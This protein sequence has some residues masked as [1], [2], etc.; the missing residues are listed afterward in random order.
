VIR[1]LSL[2]LFNDKFQNDINKWK[3]LEAETINAAALKLLSENTDALTKKGK[4][5]TFLI[6]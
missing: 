6:K 5:V 3:Q 1:D 2:R 4:D